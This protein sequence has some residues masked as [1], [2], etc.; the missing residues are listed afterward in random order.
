MRRAIP[1]SFSGPYLP[2]ALQRHMPPLSPRNRRK[3]SL[4]F[5]HWPTIIGAR[6]QENEPMVSR[7]LLLDEDSPVTSTTSKEFLFELPTVQTSED[8]KPPTKTIIQDLVQKIGMPTDAILLLNLVAIIWGSQHA[9]IKI[10]ISDI[11]PS[12]FSLVRFFFGALLA[13]PA[14]L[15]SS[16]NSSRQKENEFKMS[17]TNSQVVARWGL[18]MGFWMFLGY[19]FQ[20]IGLGVSKLQL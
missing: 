17:S 1:L 10:C 11:D 7:P 3:N 4:S 2:S 14:W 5:H 19:A 18:E 13:T 6:H 16:G 15:R 20:S 9:I 8:S 12:T